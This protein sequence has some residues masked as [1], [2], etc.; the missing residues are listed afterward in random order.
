M[1]VLGGGVA[2]PEGKIMNGDFGPAMQ[3]TSLLISLFT[4]IA[5]VMLA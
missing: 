4:V 3:L 5:D 2:S 1:Y